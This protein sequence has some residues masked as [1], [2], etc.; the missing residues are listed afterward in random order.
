MQAAGNEYTID[1]PQAIGPFQRQEVFDNHGAL[2]RAREEVKL[3]QS[4]RLGEFT[5]FDAHNNRIRQGFNVLDDGRR[6]DFQYVIDFPTGTGSATWRRTGGGPTVVHDGA[7]HHGP[8][9]AYGPGDDWI[10]LDSSTGGKGVPVFE[11][12]PLPGGDTLDSFRRTDTVAF[13]H[14]NRRTTWVQWDAAGDLRGW[15]KRHFDTAGT[16]WSDVTHSR[17]GDHRARTTIR[18]YRDGLQ[19]YDDGKAGHVLAVKGDNGELDL[20]PL[21]RGGETPGRRDAYPRLRR[22]LDR[23]GHGF[24]HRCATAVGGVAPSGERQTLQGVEAGSCPRR[25]AQGPWRPGPLWER[26]S[27]HG[28]E[29]GKIEKLM[30]GGDFQLTTE[31]IGEQRPP[32]SMRNDPALPPSHAHFGG[33]NGFQMFAWSK[34]HSTTQADAGGGLRYVAMDGGTVDIHANGSFVRS[35]TKL[36]YGNELRV[37]DYVPDPPGTAGHPLRWQ[38]GPSGGTPIRS[39]VRQP[40]PQSQD[41]LWKD[42]VDTPGVPEAQW[43]VA[44]EGLP[45]GTV[46]EYLDSSPP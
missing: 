22:R 5:E 35:K 6:T 10:R 3:R 12:R 9:K 32:V 18:E 40:T 17:M 28:K 20:E 24:R 34:T 30:K 45:D 38:E 29:S 39:G 1:L 41:T 27:P 43:R 14:F 44:R 4:P 16:G 21:R 11:R 46:R 42:L 7:F 23:Q 33:D 8:A 25:Q 13:G 26:Q 37:G 19:K 15:G 36:H 2:L 31:R